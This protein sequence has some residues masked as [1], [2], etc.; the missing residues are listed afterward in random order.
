MINR[1]PR[2]AS[3]F[4]LALAI[5][6][7]VMST[8]PVPEMAASTAQL[9][10]STRTIGLINSGSLQFRDM[11]RNR[12]LDGY[13]DWRLT[14]EQRAADLVSHMTL[15][16]KAGQLIYP[17][18]NPNAP[19]GQTATG[20]DLDGLKQTLF[21]QHA[22]H[23]ALRLVADPVTVARA[24]NAAQE[25]AETGRLGIPLTIATDS[26]HGF[27]GL[28]GA[29][30]VGGRFTPWPNPLGFAALDDE[31]LVRRQANLVR[32]D[33][34]AVGITMLLGPQIDLATEPR[35]P[36]FF[37]TYGD[38]PAISA[39]L[40]A[41]FVTGLQGSDAGLQQ[42]GVAAVI[43]HF[44]G[45]SAAIDGFDAHNRYG[46]FSAV[47]ADEFAQ[48]IKPF[49]AAIKAHAAAVMPAYSILKGLVLD[50]RETEQVGTAFNR[51]VIDGVLRKRLGFDGLVLSDWAIIND[52]SDICMIGFPEGVRPS[53]EG[54]S[55]AW[56]VE[57]LTMA[58]RVAKAMNAGVDQI[59]GAEDAGPIIEAV[60]GG[61]VSEARLDEAVR[62]VLAIDISMGLY[63]QPFVDETT[64]AATVSGPDDRRWGWS[65]QGRSTVLLENDGALPLSAGA[66][67][68]LQG[69]N[70]DLA[71][72]AGLVPVENAR[73]ADVAIMR[74][75]SPFETLHP[76]YTF[77]S[78]HQEGS[79]AFPA[80]S[81]ANKFMQSL[82]PDLPLIA[83][84][85]LDRP[86]IL[87]PFK[88]RA[89]VLLAG[90][91]ADDE[92]FLDV[93][94]GRTVP[95]GRLPF[96]LPSSMASVE[97]Q[98]PGTPSDSGDPLYPRGYRFGA[99]H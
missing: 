82:P 52:C 4:G 56:G 41:A 43:K 11:N 6:G 13:E 74:A 53:F 57:N 49:D 79:L 60:R 72:Q 18:L 44:A 50:G 95:E 15:E 10:L 37:E 65:V 21:G 99:G 94:T 40:A 23:L 66:K 54:V 25:V 20:H 86:A 5:S 68:Y 81:P 9:E 59:G 97:R 71:R 26:L 92:A 1:L 14:P 69:V 48:H 98:R 7:C 61:L 8:K 3:V 28:L 17:G 91:G 93:L 27:T 83:E 85:Q 45:Y 46:R 78:V 33:L 39:R 35:W 62:K 16:E 30:A 87:T 29:S 70:V 58:E 80:D 42:G 34:R 89:N 75:K 31:E 51:D 73:D 19:F 88:P 77:G 36:R 76:N 64:V 67:V 47:N 22:T 32:R 24:N 55:T 2:S 84:V 96:E 90:F 63:E 38:D 12:R